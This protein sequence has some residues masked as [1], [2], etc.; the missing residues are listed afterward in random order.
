MGCRIG[1]V[2]E[3][4]DTWISGSMGMVVIVTTY[5]KMRDDQQIWAYMLETDDLG[6]RVWK[7]ARQVV[8]T[9]RAWLTKILGAICRSSCA[10][11]M[12]R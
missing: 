1:D 12:W 6:G 8:D 9:S 4:S 10:I 11:P 3:L 7:E 5:L 2:L